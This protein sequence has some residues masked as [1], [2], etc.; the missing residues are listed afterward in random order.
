M[1][2]AW[3]MPLRFSAVHL[4]ISRGVLDTSGAWR[5]VGGFLPGDMEEKRQTVWPG[6]LA[7][8]HQSLCG[9]SKDT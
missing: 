6:Q 9:S 5:G 8:W 3:E 2:S 7:P 4:F 1:V